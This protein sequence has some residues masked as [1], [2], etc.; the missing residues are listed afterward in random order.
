MYF[1][2]NVDKNLLFVKY[3]WVR[4]LEQSQ[5]V[6]F[7]S[8]AKMGSRD[9]N[10]CAQFWTFTLY[11]SPADRTRWEKTM[12]NRNKSEFHEVPRP[13]TRF[14]TPD[15]KSLREKIPNRRLTCYLRS[16]A[17]ESFV[18]RQVSIS[19]PFINKQ[20]RYVAYTSAWRNIHWA[21]RFTTDLRIIRCLQRDR[22]S[23]GSSLS[24]FLTNAQ[25]R[26]RQ[27]TFVWHGSA[28][29]SRLKNTLSCWL[30]H[31]GGQIKDVK[32]CWEIIDDWQQR[33][34]VKRNEKE[35]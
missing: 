16:I 25:R 33:I 28:F 24:L 18:F 21:N 1:D 15:N 23:Q 10:V 13:P 14:S 3:P 20:G 27:I 2:L 9:V 6:A 31:E 17:Y 22:A 30:S 35:K 5:K 11:G 26:D 34:F 29:F 19:D 12:D 8:V 32:H 4:Y 7:Q